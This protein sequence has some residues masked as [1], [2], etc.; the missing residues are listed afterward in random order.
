MK[1]ILNLPGAADPAAVAELVRELK[2]PE[3]IATILVNRG[4]VAP[5]AAKS[6]L[7]P[8]LGDLHD[9]WSLDGVSAAVERVSAAIDDGE[10]ILVHGDYDVDGICS[11]AMTVR[12]LRE[13][14]AKI[15]AFVPNR[16]RDGYDFGPA[17][18][19]AAVE[20][21]AACVL[22]CDCGTTAHQAIAEARATFL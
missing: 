12:A 5:E 16:L 15:G 9:P 4:Y 18:V 6:F 2:L 22:T 7:R 1:P 20:R 17:G 10:F 3:P 11:S 8:R 19:A 14:G 13:L 21:K